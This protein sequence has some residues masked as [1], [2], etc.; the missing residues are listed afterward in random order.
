MKLKAKI[1]N[2]FIVTTLSLLISVPAFLIADTE[3][4]F[5]PPKG[6]RLA[7]VDSLPKS[8]HLMVIGTSSSHFPP[9]INLGTDN[10]QGSMKDYLKKVKEINTSQGYTWKDLGKIETKAGEASLSQ[11]ERS[12]AYGEIKLMHIMVL[13][14]GVVYIMTASALKSEF[15]KFYKDFYESFRT[16]EIK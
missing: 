15:S 10:F 12:T 16:L 7:E 8:V 1:S 11:T 3:A 2:I 4:K 5:I 13:H 9:S 6:W 14:D